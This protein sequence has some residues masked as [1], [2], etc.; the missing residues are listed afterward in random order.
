M[1]DLENTVTEMVEVADELCHLLTDV[2]DRWF[3]IGV[4]LGIKVPKLKALKGEKNPLLAMLQRWLNDPGDKT[5][6]LVVEATSHRAG[7][8]NKVAAKKVSKMR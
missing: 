5:V 6:E 7:G 8:N 1:T 4:L 3:Q 2:S